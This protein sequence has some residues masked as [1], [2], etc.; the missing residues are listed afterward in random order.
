M[1]GG[2]FTPA[3]NNG[4]VVRQSDQLLLD[5][6]P[7]RIVGA[8][9]YYFAYSTEADQTRLLDIAVDFSVNVL[10]IWAFNDFPAS[11][12]DTGVCF[13]FFNPAT[14]V[15]ELRDSS[16]GLERL[17]SAV[18]LAADRGIR[19]ILTL[20]NYYPD[21]G[22]MPQYQRWLG[23]ANLNDF[24]RDAGASALFQNWVRAVIT[25]RNTLTNLS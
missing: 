12:G 14:G 21:Y 7:F 8:N 3:P 16:F 2:D 20:T 19:L 22:G 15:P 17:D 1:S 10:R 25:R 24:Y 13:Q 23:L 18:K 9:I 4:F 5:S 6:E 11:P